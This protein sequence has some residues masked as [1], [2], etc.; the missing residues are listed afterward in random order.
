MELAKDGPADQDG[1]SGGGLALAVPP[2]PGSTAVTPAAPSRRAAW[3]VG[4]SWVLTRTLLILLVTGVLKIAPMD[5][6]TD[7]S[8]IYHGWYQVLQTGTFPM[9]DVT[10]QYPPGAALVILAPGLLPWS[11]LTSFFV[12][13]GLFDTLAMGMLLRSGL[14]RGRSLA[15]AW[16]WVIGVPLLGPTVYCRYDILVTAMAVTGLLVILRRP[17]LGGILLGVGGLMKLW[18][19]LGLA[20]T[21]RGRRTRR[22][23][24]SAV[25]AV[26]ALSFLLAAGMNGAFQFLTFQA[27]RGV[28]VESLGALPL[29]FAKMFGGWHGAVTMNYGSVEF[30]GPWVPVISKLAVGATLAGFAWLLYWRLRARRWQ[31]STTYDA[32]LAALLIFTV[33]SR[34]ISPQYLVWLVGL[35]AVCLTVR[36]TSQRPVAVLVLVATVLTT[37]EFPMNFGQVVNSMPWGVTVLASRN[38]T[39]LAATLLSCRRLWR[40][41]QGPAPAAAVERAALPEEPE[42]TYPVRPGIAYEQSLLDDIQRG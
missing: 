17:V 3:R 9:D 5:V 31:P 18:P 14:R 32:A 30:L 25:A 29:H 19:L 10:W 15:G 26:A 33:T 42:Q 37:L 27:D 41:T 22:S 21:P 24:T 36:G 8:V 23:W 34:V 1:S 38:L 28:E 40:S 4:G 2:P 35:A 6:T 13:C 7:V 16:I 20:G 39:L 12:L 11:Y